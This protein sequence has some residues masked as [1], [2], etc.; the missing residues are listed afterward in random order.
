VITKQPVLVMIQ[1]PAPGSF[2]KLPDNRV[3]SIGRS[4][5]NT[6]RAVSRS[7]SRF[8]CEVAWV[9][10]RWQLT[11]LNSK[12]GTLVNGEL[13]E[14]KCELFPGDVIRISTTVFRF[15]M[16]DESALNDSAMVAI[17]EAELNQRLSLK[18]EGS[19]SL[20]EIRARSRLESKE[21]Q[22][23]RRAK[24]RVVR[25]NLAFLGVTAAMLGVAVTGVLLFAH[26]RADVN[27][28]TGTRTQA[29]AQAALVAAEQLRE[30][31]DRAAAAATLRDL[32]ERFP[33]TESA[34]VAQ[35]ELRELNWAA[36]EEALGGLR[37]LE[38]SGDF[39]GALALCDA[40]DTGD[41][42][43]LADVVRERREFTV[44]LAH[45]SYRTAER[46][47]QKHLQ[48]GDSGS[49]LEVYR[50]AAERVGV[51]ELVEKAQ[52]AM[53]DLGGTGSG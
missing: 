49:A 18:G 35:Q 12:K 17:M 24:Q 32:L 7:V 48:D 4:S 2:Y 6:I 28:P 8:H 41:D 11:D 10:G 44:R 1:G 42:R 36:A 34:P 23:R 9:N 3:V 52:D 31:G 53:A 27:S 20:D 40:I 29:R 39:A 22:E 33:A 19:V 47:A 21:I 51:P 26:R 14:G 5:R 45:A 13:V 16:I 43:T 50:H 15:D 25:A 37:P 30:S 46:T 38:T